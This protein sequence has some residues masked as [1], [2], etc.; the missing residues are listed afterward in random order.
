MAEL[1][2]LPALLGYGVAAVA[3]LTEARRPGAAG[4]VAI[5]GVRIGWL[6]HTGLLVAQ[7]AS[8]EGFPWSSPG[9][10]LNALAWLV[11]GGYLVWGCKPR[12]RLVGLTLMP[13]AVAVLA[14][15]WAADGT[16]GEASQPGVLLGFHVVF[17]LSAVAAFTVAGGFAATFLWQERRLK[18]HER[19]VLRVPVPPLA[20]LERA[21]GRAVVTGI[22]AL[23]LGVAA[24]IVTL[25][26]S[27]D[28]LDATML[29]TPLPLVLYGCLAAL[30]AAGRLAG[31]RL[32]RADLGA[33]ASVALV[34]SIAHFA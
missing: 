24:G 1:L 21:T 3:L 7:A 18:R 29:L 16:A 2:V 30:W 17:M 25:E 31:R 14:V 26:R 27:G 22:V 34:L 23:A 6:A 15:A 28:A 32:A 12:F 20:W 4:R 10:A 9:G 11:V 13:V 8:A 33:F 19:S 5:W